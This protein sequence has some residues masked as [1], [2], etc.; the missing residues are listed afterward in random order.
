MK[1]LE[2]IRNV[3]SRYAAAGPEFFTPTTFTK[4]TKEVMEVLAKGTQFPWRLGPLSKQTHSMGKLKESCL[5]CKI[6]PTDSKKPVIAEVFASITTLNLKSRERS[7]GEVFEPTYAVLV[8][9]HSANGTLLNI[10]ENSKEF[11]VVARWLQGIPAN[12]PHDVF[13]RI[14]SL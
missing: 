1:D 8:D 4:V 12:L 10:Q 14:Q 6:S 2:L 13:A 7:V 9:I 3:V 5:S 11:S